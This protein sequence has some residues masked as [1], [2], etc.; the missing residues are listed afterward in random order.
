[1]LDRCQSTRCEKFVKR[2]LEQGNG[3][4]SPWEFGKYRK[5]IVPPVR[6]AQRTQ[7]A[8]DQ[9]LPATLVELVKLGQ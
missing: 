1:V 9:F 6:A 8:I 4:S 7:R 5:A 3:D 2:L